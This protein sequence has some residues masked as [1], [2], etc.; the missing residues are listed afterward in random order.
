MN[1]HKL[2][3]H[4]GSSGQELFTT[5]AQRTRRFKSGCFSLFPLC[6]LR[7]SVVIFVFGFIAGCQSTGNAPKQR[8]PSQEAEAQKQWNDA[9]ANVLGGLATDQYR[10]GD[11]DRCQT[12]L[13]EALK[14]AP[15]SAELHLLSARVSIEQGKLEVAE[16]QLDLARKLAP[17]NPQVDYLTGVLLQRWQ[18]PQKA[19]DAYAAA[20]KKNP[21]ELGFLMAEAE[22][23]VALNKQS[24]AIDLLKSK[25]SSFEHSP[26]IRDAL[27]QL[28][29]EQGQ[30]ATAVPYLRE[31]SV[32]ATEDQTIREHLGFA[33]YYDKQ[34]DQAA[35]QFALLLKDDAYAKRADVFGVLGICQCMTGHLVDARQNL[36]T[37]VQ[38]DPASV[39]YWL[40]L[41]RVSAQLNDLPRAELD[42]RKAL[43]IEPG[44]SEAHMLLGY[45]RLRENHLPQALSAFHTASQLETGDT[46]S[47]CMQGYVLEKMGRSDEA[48]QLYARALKIKPNDELA[49]RLIAR[50][51]DK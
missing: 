17:E 30:F 22:M 26:A 1:Q 16:A 24:D 3:N 19:Y 33:L 5:E 23:L 15:D 28:L 48:I 41:G 12:T 32:L 34:F 35:D 9:R 20:A 51:D 13:D 43:S 47:L 39:G 36:E 11:F 49:G 37:A 21:Q 42:A 4:P 38:L 46:V 14:M 40:A 18:Q 25:V 8:T 29:V 45:V 44:N 2:L 7:V 31:A 6:A 10:N 27:G 50:A